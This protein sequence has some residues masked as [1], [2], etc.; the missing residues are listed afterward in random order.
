MN[1]S[2]ADCKTKVIVKL[3]VNWHCEYHCH[4]SKFISKR[5]L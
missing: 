2:D 1:I 3:N 4:R 5:K